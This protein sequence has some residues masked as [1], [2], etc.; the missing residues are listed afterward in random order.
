VKVLFICTANSCRSQMAE[1]W[2]RHLF[3]A[4]WSV[5]SAG[6]LTY[7]ITTNTREAMAAVGLDMAGQEP[8]TIDRFKLDT[9]DLVVTL[10]EEAGRFLPQLPDPAR[11]VHRPVDDPMGAKGS[12]EEVTAAFTRGR[13]LIQ[14]IVADVVAGRICPGSS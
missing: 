14:A 2:A 3:P 1:A 5:S 4:D 9:F 6:L 11:H 10:S 7:R 13:D 12:P 8:K